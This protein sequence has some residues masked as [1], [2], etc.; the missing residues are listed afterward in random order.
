MLERRGYG[1]RSFVT[2]KSTHNQRI[3][4]LWRDINESCTGA[5]YTKFYWMEKIGLLDPE[6]DVDIFCL[7][8]VAEHLIQAAVVR[9]QR[10]WNYHKIRTE[11]HKSLN[12]IFIAGLT[13]LRNSGCTLSELEQDEPGRV[14]REPDDWD[15]SVHTIPAVDV[16]AF[17]CPLTAE[18][19]FELERRIRKEN[20][21]LD[22]LHIEYQ[23]VKNYVLSSID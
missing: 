7:H 4:R 9:F 15:R 21:D 5:F 19:L 16:P 10:S 12:Q 13:A 6:D 17:S 18:Q 3:E 14:T 8:Y 11:G 1:R 2:G 22:N 23:E 20:I